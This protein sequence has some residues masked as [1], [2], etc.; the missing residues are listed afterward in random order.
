MKYLF[1]AI[2][3]FAC[4]SSPRQSKVR[5]ASTELL[6]TIKSAPPVTAK[7][8][9]LETAFIK[10]TKE[11]FHKAT[12]DLYGIT[13]GKIR[14]S[15]GRIIICDP[16]HIDEYGI[17]FTQQF[18][19]GEF[20]VQLS[21]AKLDDDETIAFARI[22]FSDQPVV[23]W[24]YAL[25]EGQKQMQIMEDREY[26]FGVDAGVAI[27]FDA[28]GKNVLNQNDMNSMETLLFREMDKHF[29]NTWKY[30][31]YSFDKHNLAAFSTG[32]GDGNYGTY[33]GFDAAGN[34]CRLVA[35]FDFFNWRKQ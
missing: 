12:M 17:P 28:A 22:M 10:G 29:H 18:P 23:R 20:P 27:L 3:L 5:P 19:L 2:V 6:D 4:N 7:P 34:P 21:I 30:A 9:I 1:I 16:L 33:I 25:Q 26:G 31:M 14:I 13:I 15:S 35:D 11:R 8:L 24:E 32:L